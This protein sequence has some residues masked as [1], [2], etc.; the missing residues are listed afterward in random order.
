MCAFICCSYVTMCTWCEAYIFSNTNDTTLLYT[1]KQPGSVDLLLKANGARI[2]TELKLITDMAARERGE[3]PLLVDTHQST[4]G[5]D[6]PDEFLIALQ[7]TNLT[8]GRLEPSCN[9][10]EYVI[11]DHHE[12]ASM[13][14]AQLIKLVDGSLPD[15]DVL[16]H[17]RQ[18]HVGKFNPAN[19]DT[20]SLL[21]IY[22]VKVSGEDA[23]RSCSGNRPFESRISTVFGRLR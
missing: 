22:D 18:S 14:I 17:L 1:L 13:L 2:E 12:K 19:L 5:A 7:S 23:N 16:R 6:E 4:V 11:N 8:R 10:H 9:D 21:I 3:E 20:G 15:K